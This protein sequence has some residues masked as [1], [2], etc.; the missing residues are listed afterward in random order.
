MTENEID[1]VI[2]DNAIHAAFNNVEDELKRELK[3]VGYSLRELSEK[4]EALE[5]RVNKLDGDP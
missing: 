4:V 2:I 1:D 5:V 3:K